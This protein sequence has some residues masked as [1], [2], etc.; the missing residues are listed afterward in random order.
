MRVLMGAQVDASRACLSVTQQ[1]PR[2]RTQGNE[3][4]PVS[5]TSESW[6]NSYLLPCFI[7]MVA[8]AIKL[9]NQFSSVTQSCPTL[10]DLM[11]HSMPGFPFQHQIP[12]STQTHV[13]CV[14]DAIQ[15]S[16][17]LK[18]PSPPA[19]NLS[20]HQGFFKWVS[21]LHEVAKVMEF[22]LQHQSFQWTLRTDLL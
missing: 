16:H 7:T 20:Q 12:E 13:H 21:T 9:W 1:K 22:Q 2:V 17:P 8:R 18:P 4:A 15:P 3:L 14:S 19:L 6:G 10:C 11:N 5:K